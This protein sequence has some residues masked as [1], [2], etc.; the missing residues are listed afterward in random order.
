M[1]LS[2]FDESCF[3]ALYSYRSSI[4]WINKVI[5]SDVETAMTDRSG[6]VQIGR[7]FFNQSIQNLE[8]LS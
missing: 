3:Q 1:D 7:K 8:D 5:A 4:G 2:N 6:E